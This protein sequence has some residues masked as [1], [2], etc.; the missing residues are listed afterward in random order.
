MVLINNYKVDMP[1]NVNA[2]YAIFTIEFEKDSRLYV[3]HVL[4]R[5]VISAVASLILNAFDDYSATGNSSIS[6]AIRE[7][8]YITVGLIGSNVYNLKQ[9]FELK[10]KTIISNKA[11]IPYGYNQINLSCSKSQEEKKIVKEL[12]TTNPGMRSFSLCK[13]VYRINRETGKSAMFNSVKEA[14]E[15]IGGKPNNI[16]A[17]CRGSL[18]TAY[19]FEWCYVNPLGTY[20]K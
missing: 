11:F 10:Y 4:N 15:A 3:G 7:S 19:G 17:C 6:Q 16:T 13:P 20:R 12:L 1:D 14:A 8:N 2:K 5:T 9:L 18:H